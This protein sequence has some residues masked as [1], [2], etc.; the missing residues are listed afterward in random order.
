[1]SHRIVVLLPRL[2]GWGPQL[3]AE[4][5]F[6]ALE[7][8]FAKAAVSPALSSSL[9]QLRLALF[10]Q[11]AEQQVPVAALS[12]LANNR[13]A[14][15]DPAHCLRLDPVI[16]QADMSSVMLVG[17]GFTNFPIAYQQQVMQ[18]VQEVLAAEDLVLQDSSEGYWTIVLPVAP[19]VTFTALDDALGADVTDCL[20]AGPDARLWKKLHNEI[21]MAL[22]ACAANQERRQRNEAVI[23][24]IWFWGGGSL[25]K[26]AGSPAFDV[27]YSD[28]P[29]SSGLA[30]LQNIPRQ[31]L[32]GLFEAGHLDELSSAGSVLVDWAVPAST[33]QQAEPVTPERLEQFLDV[34]L[35]QLKANGGT[36]E[37][38]SPEQSWCLRRSDLWKFWKRPQ[39]LAPQFSAL[40]S[41]P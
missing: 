38:H 33:A 29:V 26:V 31:K 14:A 19:Q 5:R 18:L 36:L 10:G 7:T 17:S 27:V 23:N 16:L 11:Q 41:R 15:D 35:G 22:H 34:L 8:F 39:P 32:S 28:D 2:S 9:D 13:L 21:Q 4:Q 6:A 30:Q 37:L 25:P 3:A 1:M 40:Q 24:A 20:P 12:L